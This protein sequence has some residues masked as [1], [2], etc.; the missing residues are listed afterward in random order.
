[1][2]VV[3]LGGGGR[4]RWGVS[5]WWRGVTGGRR[6]RQA[7]LPLPCPHRHSTAALALRHTHALMPM[8]PPPHTHISNHVHTRAHEKH[9][10]VFGLLNLIIER[11][12]PDISPHMG[13]LLPLLPRVWQEAADQSLL[14][15]Q[16]RPSV[17][18][19][20]CVGVWVCR[21]VH[22]CVLCVCVCACVCVRACVRACVCVRACMRACVRACVRVRARA[23]ARVGACVRARVFVGRGVCFSACNGPAHVPP[24]RRRNKHRKCAKCQSSWG[25]HSL[26]A[27]PPLTH[28]ITHTHSH[29]HTHHAT[30]HAHR[31]CAACRCW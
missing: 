8:P 14:R 20:V 5:C 4:A 6:A 11:L 7:W 15:I 30:H 13:A 28:T 9:A 17:F 19:A 31:C 10:Q 22:V 3:V 29:T 27:P 16:V 2:V 18:V 23:R 12:G 25:A 21:C 26:C 1:V 24:P